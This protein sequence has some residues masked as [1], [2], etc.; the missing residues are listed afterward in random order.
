MGKDSVA[1]QDPEYKNR[2]ETFSDESQRGNFSIKLNNLQH[3][4]A[5]KYIC[6]ITNS[7]DSQQETVQLI[8][9]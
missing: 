3:T 4:D 6:Y 5:G 1:K 2:A 8:I 7:S 9:S